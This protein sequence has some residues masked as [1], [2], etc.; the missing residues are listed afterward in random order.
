MAPPVQGVGKL[1]VSD[2]LTDISYTLF[3][4]VVNTVVPAGG[5][6]VGAAVVN[7]WDDSMYLGAQVLVGVLGGDLEVVVITAVNPGVSF[8]AT[9]VNAH[10]A[11]EPIYGPTFP[12]QSVAGDPFWE[13]GEMLQYI[14]NALNE[15]LLRVPL[16]YKI[17][18][19]ITVPFTHAFTPLPSDCMMPVRVAPFQDIGSGGFGDGGFGDGGFGGDSVI[20]FSYP[21]RETSQS[22]L[23][24]TNYRW[25]QEAA[26][27]PYV[28]YRDKIPLQN[29]GI[30]PRANNNVDLE[31]IYANRSAETLGLADGFC[32][33]DPFLPIIKAHTLEMA[34]SKDG[35]Q[36]SPGMSK[37]WSGRYESGVKIAKMILDVINDTSL[38][39]Q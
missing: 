14:S 4:G 12:V 13:Q 33:P 11:G 8:T 21:L 15:F 27:L 38:Q 20:V 34:Y 28:Y 17:A 36:R 1:I 3:E 37:F 24:G 31:I 29:V 18:S 35:E 25:A 7:A 5:I 32:I 19:P 30:W 9:F 22:N 2:I 39:M 6:G 16:A 26:A 10:P 23:D